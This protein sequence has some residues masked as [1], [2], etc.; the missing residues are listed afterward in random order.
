MEIKAAGHNTLFGTTQGI[1]LVLVH[2]T[3]D[4][5][6]T[7]KLPI[8]LVPGLGG[9]Y[10]L[11]FWQ[12]K[13]ALKI[14]SL[15]QGSIVDLGSFSIHL[16]RSDNLDNVDL[17]VAKKSKR[18]ESACWAISGKVFGN[19]TVLTASAPQKPI[20]L[21][22][23]SMNIDQRSLQDGSSVVGG[24][25]KGLEKTVST[26]CRIKIKVWVTDAR[27][28]AMN[29]KNYKER[30]NANESELKIKRATNSDVAVVLKSALN[31]PQKVTC[32]RSTFKVKSDCIFKA[33]QVVFGWRQKHCT[34]CGTTLFVCKESQDSRCSNC[35]VMLVPR[36]K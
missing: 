31:I 17:A 1:L 11:Q 27:N 8:V 24:C 9:N 28:S 4:V 21:S 32:T 12:L 34:D 15:R 6:R 19:Q 3:Q 29:L 30:L 13:K 5:S 35:P 10:F 25:T 14:F 36:Q 22:A 2:D 20:A 23:V 18:T 26:M 16:T 33:R 7:V